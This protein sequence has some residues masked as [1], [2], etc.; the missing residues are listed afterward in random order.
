M[1]KFL[2]HCE[3]EKKMSAYKT[4][5]ISLAGKSKLRRIQSEIIKII[6]SKRLMIF[7]LLSILHPYKLNMLF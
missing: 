2:L 7:N 1:F 6:E 5:F 3:L 4:E